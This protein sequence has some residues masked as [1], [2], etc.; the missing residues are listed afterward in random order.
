MA[1]VATS[2]LAHGGALHRQPPPLLTPQAAHSGHSHASAPLLLTCAPTDA[3]VDYDE[4]VTPLYEHIGH[5]EWDA[6]A[7]RC[8]SHPAEAATWVVRHRRDADGTKALVGGQHD[9]L[10]RFLPVHSACAL[11]PPP[12]FLRTLLQA[13]PDGARTLDDQGMLP[14]HYACGARC[15]REV[16]YL[17]LM[18]FPQAALKEDPNGMLPLHYLAQWGPREGRGESGVVDMVCVAT[19]HKVAT[20]KDGDGN[21]AEALALRA[22]YEGHAEVAQKI[23]DFAQRHG[24]NLPGAPDRAGPNS[25]RSPKPHLSVQTTSTPRSIAGASRASSSADKYSSFEDDAAEVMED[26]STVLEHVPGGSVEISL[27]P[28]GRGQENHVGWANGVVTPRS[29]KNIMGKLGVSPVY[30]KQRKRGDRYHSWDGETTG[31]EP[32]DGGLNHEA[33]YASH[34]SLVGHSPGSRRHA[35]S[36][37]WDRA[38]QQSRPGSS[39]KFGRDPPMGEPYGNPSHQDVPSVGGSTW[40]SAPSATSK[41][42]GTAL[43]P[44][45]NHHA[46]HMSQGFPPLSPRAVTTPKSRN[47]RSRQVREQREPMSEQD[48]QDRRL[49]ELREELSGAAVC[50]SGNHAGSHAGNH[51]G[52]HAGSHAQGSAEHEGEAALLDEIRRLKAEKDQ[53]EGALAKITMLAPVWSADGDRPVDED[54]GVSKLTF[55]EHDELDNEAGTRGLPMSVVEEHDGSVASAEVNRLLK[56]KMAIERALQEAREGDEASQASKAYDRTAT[57]ADLVAKI[58]QQARQLDKEKLRSAAL[59][60]EV[61]GLTEAHEAA[62]T[63]HGEAVAAHLAEVQSLRQSLDKAAAEMEARGEGQGERK[64]ME[65]EVKRA[66]DQCWAA[67]NGEHKARSD[68]KAKEAAWEVER[69]RLEAEVREL[70]QAFSV[71]G[72]FATGSG[73]GGASNVALRIKLETSVKEAEDMRKYNAAMRKEHGETIHE[74]EKTLDEER[75]GKT[76]SMSEVVRLKYRIATLE[77]DLAGARDDATMAREELRLLPRAG[78]SGVELELYQL[79]DKLSSRLEDAEKARKKLDEMKADLDAKGGS[80]LSENE[81]LTKE[82]AVAEGRR[83]ELES[84]VAAGA[85]TANEEEDSYI[86]QIREL[87]KKIQALQEGEEGNSQKLWEANKL[88]DRALQEKED[89]MSDKLRAMKKEHERAAMEK[90]DEHLAALRECKKK[91]ERALRASEESYVKQLR[92]A[93]MKVQDLIDKE[94][95][96]LREL[97]EN[98][99]KDA[100]T[101]RE[102]EGMVRE[103]TEERNNAFERIVREKD[104]EH[105]REVAR[106]E[107]ELAELRAEGKA[108]AEDRTR[109][110]ELEAQLLDT[111][112]DLER[113]RRKHKSEMNQASNTLELQ[114]SKEGRLQSHIQSLEKQITDMVS[115][116]EGRLQDAFYDNM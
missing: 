77:Q 98:K 99:A 37:S 104:E 14:L 113:Q 103:R 22:E 93:K 107:A 16:L 11:N 108:V 73:E 31:R 89:E 69:A 116:Y 41:P 96:L 55:A 61:A 9:I 65:E 87:K 23:R 66:N 91:S 68:L 94:D 70:K 13:Y 81:R 82:L 27:S 110:S 44:P 97:N 79:K 32:W 53:A 75:R 84:Q 74:L 18:R 48:R 3:S 21:T 57:V 85:K 83:K 6:A 62:T 19:G 72:A 76:E 56:E 115:D 112:K 24:A 43:L 106:L 59:K 33:S 105:E 40:T 28:G 54:D 60:K 80:L 25:G 15:S 86:E 29:S 20:S 8:S 12:A 64:K 1:A 5:S 102:I 38:D 10:W 52:G 50:G 58:S 95:R 47:M 67:Q 2:P 45:K 78:K 49:A 26:N 111:K 39:G 90:E 7:S 4:N 71:D 34:R 36:F 109:A 51:S 88:R 42:R 30:S 92:E 114:K 17:L 35:R 46:S 100:L 101:Q 63:D